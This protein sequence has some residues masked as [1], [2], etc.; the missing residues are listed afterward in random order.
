MV[1]KVENV[2]TKAMQCL[3]I[4]GVWVGRSDLSDDTSFSRLQVAYS[5]ELFDDWN[6]LADT[7]LDFSI[8]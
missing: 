4:K 1:C 5:R 7:M 2:G 8:R 6:R 3:F